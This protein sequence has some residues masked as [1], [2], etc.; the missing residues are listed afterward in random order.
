[1]GVEVIVTLFTLAEIFAVWIKDHG[2][3]DLYQSINQSWPLIL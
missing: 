1:M 2:N 3:V